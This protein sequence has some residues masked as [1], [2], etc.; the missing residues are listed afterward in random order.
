MTAIDYLIKEMG[1][2]TIQVMKS[3]KNTMDPKLI[4][5]PGKMLDIKK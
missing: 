5:N 3:I 4:L 2:N 1:F